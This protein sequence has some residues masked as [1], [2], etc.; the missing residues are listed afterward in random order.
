M[1]KFHRHTPERSLPQSSLHLQ[2]AIY[3]QNM[4][5]QH[6]RAF[7]SASCQA[8]GQYKRQRILRPRRKPQIANTSVNAQEGQKIER[9]F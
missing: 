6:A 2:A 5:S 1:G 8:G 4:N 3:C 9:R 7:R